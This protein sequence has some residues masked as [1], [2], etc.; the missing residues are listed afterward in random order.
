[1]A[2]K[3]TPRRD[4]SRSRRGIHQAVPAFFMKPPTKKAGTA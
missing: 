3:V 4:I 1:M 2:A